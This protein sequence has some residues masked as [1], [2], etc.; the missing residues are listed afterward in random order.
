METLA[1]DNV[2]GAGLL[3][4]PGCATPPNL[5]PA[6]SGL[7][8]WPVFHEVGC[9]AIPSDGAEPKMCTCGVS[10][11]FK[12]FAYSPSLDSMAWREWTRETLVEATVRQGL[13]K[14]HGGGNHLIRAD[15]SDWGY[16]RLPMVVKIARALRGNLHAI[17]L[18]DI[19]EAWDCHWIFTGPEARGLEAYGV[20]DIAAQVNLA[21]LAEDLRELLQRTPTEEEIKHTMQP[22]LAYWAQRDHPNG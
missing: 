4:R 9:A 1:S 12:L 8:P 3:K 22:W 20:P 6:E 2:R 19:V 11:R 14:S 10:P 13:I 5:T 7:N 17:E 16:Q 15:G 18:Q 21:P